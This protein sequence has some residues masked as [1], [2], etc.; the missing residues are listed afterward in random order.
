MIYIVMIIAV[1]AFLAATAA[2][3]TEKLTLVVPAASTRCY[4][5][6]FNQKTTYKLVYTVNT[7]RD[8][9]DS[10]G[11]ARQHQVYVVNDVDKSIKHSDTK[12]RGHFTITHY[13]GT[14]L[15]AVCADN[16]TN[17]PISVKIEQSSG[18]DLN[19]FSN[20]PLQVSSSQQ[21]ESL[22]LNKS[23][24]ILESVVKSITSMEGLKQTEL[25]M[26]DHSTGF[27][28]RLLSYSGVGILALFLLGCGQ[29]VFLNNRLLSRKL[30]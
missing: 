16:L 24:D 3:I 1:V 6:I 21:N 5:D 19:D 11:S 12:R 17:G 25:R 14:Q 2:C 4:S 10:E 15:L 13:N 7:T 27:V 20:L 28:S 23:L 22:S 8:V 9:A 29:V 30:A 26:I 18:L